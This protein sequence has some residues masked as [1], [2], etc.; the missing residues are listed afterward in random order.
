VVE[1]DGGVAIATLLERINEWIT[2]LKQ[3][4]MIPLLDNI[5]YS[6]FVDDPPL[7]SECSSNRDSDFVVVSMRPTAFPFMMQ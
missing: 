4:S 5:G 1:N 6:T 3:K 2:A 7:L